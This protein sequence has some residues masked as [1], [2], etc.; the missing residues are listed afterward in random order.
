[1]EEEVSKFMKNSEMK[2]KKFEHMDKVA[3]SIV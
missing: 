2:H 1:M 3:R